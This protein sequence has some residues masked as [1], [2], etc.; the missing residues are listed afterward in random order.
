VAIEMCIKYP[1]S[2][3]RNRGAGI[4]KQHPTVQYHPCYIPTQLKPPLPVLP[5]ISTTDYGGSS[6]ACGCASEKYRH[7]A[8]FY[9]TH[10]S[11]T[12]DRAAAVGGDVCPPGPPACGVSPE[13]DV[14]ASHIAV[15]SSRLCNTPPPPKKCKTGLV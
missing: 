2:R 7:R 11:L 6:W 8:C 5:S 12:S 10:P 13:S 15:V 14:C 1:G 4:M 9:A 3:T